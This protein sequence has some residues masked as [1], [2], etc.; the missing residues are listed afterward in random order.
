MTWIY[1]LNLYIYLILNNK[2]EELINLLRIDFELERDII[3][4]NGKNYWNLPCFRNS[5]IEIPDRI[6]EIKSLKKAIC[7]F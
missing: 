1:L 3:F 6:F 4:E 7:Q 2:R 5:K